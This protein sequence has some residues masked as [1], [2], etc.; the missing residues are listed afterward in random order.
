MHLTID[1]QPMKSSLAKNTLVNTDWEFVE[2][3]RK[4]NYIYTKKRDRRKLKRSSPFAQRVFSMY[5]WKSYTD[6]PQVYSLTHPQSI[7]LTAIKSKPACVI[8]M[9]ATPLFKFLVKL[10]CL[11]HV[12]LRLDEHALQDLDTHTLIT[13]QDTFAY[14]GSVKNILWHAPC[15]THIFSASRPRCP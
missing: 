4:N 3:R 9:F 5:P 15:R 12:C 11:D 6:I 7:V 2:T 1:E 10:K 8:G 13:F 14:H